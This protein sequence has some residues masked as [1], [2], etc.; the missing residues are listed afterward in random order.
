M[1]PANT[2]GAAAIFK[3]EGALVGTARFLNEEHSLSVDNPLY[4]GTLDHIMIPPK[5]TFPS[6]VHIIVII[7]DVFVNKDWLCVSP[8][9]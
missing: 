4:I 8:G 6:S 2:L 3:L 5:I 9:D 1:A 7:K